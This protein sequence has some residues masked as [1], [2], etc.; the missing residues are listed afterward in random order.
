VGLFLPSAEFSAVDNLHKYLR[1]FQKLPIYTKMVLLPF[2]RTHL[3]AQKSGIVS[4]L[5]GSSSMWMPS[6]KKYFCYISKV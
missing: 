4:K 5:R 6:S 2:I 3:V 1:Y